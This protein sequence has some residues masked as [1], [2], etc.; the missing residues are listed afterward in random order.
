MPHLSRRSAL[1][2]L[3]SLQAVFLATASADTVAYWNFSNIPAITTAGLPG[4]NGIP[5]TIAASSGTGNVVLTNWLGNVDDFGGSTVNAQNGDVAG[6]SLSLIAGASPFPGNNSFIDLTLSMTGKADPII[7]Y[8]TQRT[9]TGF[10]TGVWSYSTDGTTFTAVPSGSVSPPASYGLQTIDMSSVNA[11]DGAA[12][13]TLRYTLSGASAAA[14]NNRIDNLLVSATAVGG[15]TTPPGIASRTPADDATNVSLDSVATELTIAFDENINLTTG[16]IELRRVSDNVLVNSFDVTNFDD[17]DLNGGILKLKMD[18]PLAYSTAYWVKIPAGAITDQATPTANA[19]AGITTNTGWNFTTAAA[20]T[21]PTVVVNK[22]SNGTPDTVEL[23]VIGNGTPGSTVDLRGMIV[24]DFSG[25]TVGEGDGGGSYTFSTDTTWS[26]VKAGTLIT[27]PQTNTA[28]DTDATD[29]AL[30]VGLDNTTY[31]AAAGSF[32]IS[33]QDMVMIKA[34]GSPTSGTTGGI[35]ILGGGPA[36]PQYT[37]FTGAKLLA[38]AGGPGVVVDNATSALADYMSGTG[39]TGNTTLTPANFG[40]ANNGTNAS[41]VSAL[42]GVNPANGDGVVVLA[43]ATGASPYVGSGIF[44]RGQTGQSVSLTLT[45]EVPSATLSSVTIVVPAALGAPSSVS[46]SGAGAGSATN[47]I[48]LQT[49]TISNAQVTTSAPLVV[50]IN[51]LSTPSP[52]ALTDT[53]AYGFT[54]STTGGGGTLTPIGLQP[55]AHVLVPINVLRDVDAT[56]IA[57]DAGAVVAVEGVS[58]SANFSVSNTQAYIQDTTAGINLFKSTLLNTPLVRGNRYAVLGTIQ[59]FSGLTEIVPASESDIVNLGASTE[60][61]SQT[62]TV[63]GVLAVAEAKEGSL[64][65][66]QNLFKVSGAWPSGTPTGNNIVMRDAA[67]NEITIRLSPTMAGMAEPSYPVTITG[68][69][70]QFDGSNPFNSGYQLLPRDSADFT[71]GSLSDYD[72]WASGPSGA[73]GGS[74]ADPDGDGKD[75]AFEYAFGL[76]ASSGGSVN[77]YVTTLSKTTAK[78][79]YTRRTQSL[80]GLTYKVFTST[81]LLA[82][83]WVQDTTAT[84]TV[85]GTTGEVQTVEVTLSAPAPLTAPRLFVRVVAE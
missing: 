34:A 36:G 68:V 56:G 13:V 23:L 14:G 8:A 1:L 35:H 5:T 62:F 82:P 65:T 15:D 12:N 61:A 33:N 17:V 75:N 54:V 50:T 24:K 47:S 43:N 10:T 28:A 27:L 6:V 64:V 84:Q 73:A 18:T 49:V 40:T 55:S 20:P 69:L 79:T 38:S 52:S 32:N 26:A 44:A 3:A 72:A 46:L 74:A 25:N 78:F 30:N 63:P 59:Q 45:A 77:P 29:F 60:Q 58:S 11:L 22:Y 67:N 42:R 21:A 83:S 80:T 41:Y 57:L 7:T 76:N 39:A 53:G 71:A 19:F 4:T 16:I 2:A 70:T 37:N 48:N 81:T 9:T 66:L 85:V 51:G 31:F